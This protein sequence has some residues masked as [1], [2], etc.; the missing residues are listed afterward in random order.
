MKTNLMTKQEVCCTIELTS[1]T[2][3]LKLGDN[4]DAKTTQP[5]TGAFDLEE[6]TP[7]QQYLTDLAEN[8]N[9]REWGAENAQE[10]RIEHFTEARV[11][12]SR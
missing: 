6:Q 3:I 1:Q 8:H 2:I 10:Q 5:I 7:E 12:H 4:T 11:W 9:S